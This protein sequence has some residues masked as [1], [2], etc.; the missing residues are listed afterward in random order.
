MNNFVRNTLDVIELFLYQ[1][2]RAFRILLH[3][4]SL[5]SD[6]YLFGM[7]TVK[8]LI[9]SSQD[10]VFVDV[11]GY[12][13]DTSNWVLLNVNSIKSI[14]V[15]E[16]F[17]DNYKKLKMRFR[18][19]ENVQV[20]NKAV[21]SFMG[22]GD[23]NVFAHKGLNSLY[24][25][26]EHSYSFDSRENSVVVPVDVIS[27]DGYFEDCESQFFVKIDVQGAEIDVLKGMIG[28]FE[29]D[30]VLGIIIEISVVDFYDSH[31]LSVDLIVFLA[32]YNFVIKSINYGYFDRAIGRPLEYDF[33]FG[34]V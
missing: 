11:G 29:S 23:L 20:I 18:T 34:K 32:K 7:R 6:F 1:S 30:R 8:E 19:Q 22:Q 28:L 25:V 21:S 2:K 10:V 17:Y 14:V 26:G 27:L 9:S 16:P 24:A 13:G 33:V 5:E 12:K 15:F 3:G 4:K 31:S